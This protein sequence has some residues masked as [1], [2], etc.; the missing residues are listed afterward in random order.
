MWEK[1][2]RSVRLSRGKAVMEPMHKPI[3]KRFGVL[4]LSTMLLAALLV[5][6][7][8][9][10]GETITLTG[11]ISGM[12]EVPENVTRVILNGVTAKDFESGVK[13]AGTAEVAL[14]DGTENVC[15]IMGMQ[16]LKLTGGG[17]LLGGS[18]IYAFGTLTLDL[19]GN[20]VLEGGQIAAFGGDVIINS[21]TY[22]LQSLPDGGG[23]LIVS[24]GGDVQLNG[25]DVQVYSDSVAVTSTE[26]EITV[27]ESAL[28]VSAQDAAMIAE[29]ITLPQAA[30]VTVEIGAADEQSSGQTVLKG[31]APARRLKLT[32]DGAEADADPGEQVIR[33]GKSDVGASVS[34][35]ARSEDA[36]TTDPTVRTSGSTAGKIWIPAA[37][38]LAVALAAAVWY[39]GKKNKK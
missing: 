9:A 19:T 23:G 12:Y 7:A 29:T 20:V 35:G 28:D 16:D 39:F 31:G 37:V 26:G 21:G 33:E 22:R 3:W 24:S 5:F 17:A 10:A 2:D 27:S 34:L 8:R 18:G 25:G 4:L 36:E 38:I 15:G 1:R 13:I 32:K 11:E 14:A 6:P 30:A